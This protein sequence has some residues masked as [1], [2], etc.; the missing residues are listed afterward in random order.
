MKEKVGNFARKKFRKVLTRTILGKRPC[1]VGLWR[2]VF[3]D[4]QTGMTKEDRG[5]VG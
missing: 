2:D 5:S 1:Q 4:P 3:F